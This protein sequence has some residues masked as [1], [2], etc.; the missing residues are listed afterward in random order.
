MSTLEITFA[1]PRTRARIALVELLK[2]FPKAFFVEKDVCRYEVTADDAVARELVADGNW[3]VD[4]VAG[5][6]TTS[7]NALS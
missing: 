4:V 1:G 5:S 3:H 6:K 7:V 2:R